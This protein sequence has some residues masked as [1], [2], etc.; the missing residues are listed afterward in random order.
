MEYKD[1]QFYLHKTS[2]IDENVTIGKN[3][4]IWHWCHISRNVKIGKNCIFG[5]NTFLGSNVIVGDNCKIQNNV[6]IYDGVEIANNVFIGPSVVFT[7]IVNPRSNIERKKEFKKTVIQEGVSIGANSTIVC[8][9][10][11]NKYCF[12]GAGSVV[13][14]DV[15]SF[16]LVYG[17]PASHRGWFS[18]SGIKLD[19][20]FDGNNLKAKCN[21][22]GKNYFLK[23]GILQ[24]E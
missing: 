24:E 19:L 14:K 13:T 21:S 8:G 22:S 16:S 12:I 23:N 17:N 11:L 20:P 2:I 6:S 3:T 10:N 7:N 1:S 18:R 5:Q 9:N 4:K 15:K